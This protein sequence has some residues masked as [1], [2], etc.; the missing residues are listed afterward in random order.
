MSG[1]KMFFF[2]EASFADQKLMTDF[3]EASI[4]FNTMKMFGNMIHGH[5]G[6]EYFSA[7]FQNLGSTPFSL[8]SR[9]LTLKTSY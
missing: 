3:Q 4:G 7:Y 1:E 6:H 9:T 2:L 5:N 8:E